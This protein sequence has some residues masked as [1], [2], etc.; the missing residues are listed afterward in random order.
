VNTYRTSDLCRPPGR[1]RPLRDDRRAFALTRSGAGVDLP[2]F[3]RGRSDMS[4][5]EDAS[6]VAR[7]ALGGRARA[8]RHDEDRHRPWRKSDFPADDAS[9]DCCRVKSHEDFPRHI[10]LLFLVLGIQFRW[11]LTLGTLAHALVSQAVLE[12]NNSKETAWKE[13]YEHDSYTLE[14]ILYHR[15]QDLWA[16][17]TDDMKVFDTHGSAQQLCTQKV[18][19][20]LLIAFPLDH[21]RMQT[22]LFAREIARMM[23]WDGDSKGDVN[24]HFASV[25][26]LHRTMGY[27]GN[28]SIEDVLKSVLMATLKA[29]TNHSL[30]DAYHKVLD[31]LDNDKE[32]T[33]ALIQDACARQFRR[34]PDER[35]PAAWNHDPPGTPRRHVGPSGATRKTR[36]Q[37]GDPVSVSAYL[38]NFLDD[39]GVKS[40]KV[41]K[42]ACLR[43]EAPADWHSGDAVRAL[44]TASLPF[45]PQSLYSDSEA[46]SDNNA[47]VSIVDS[48]SD[49]S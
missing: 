20:A 26:E 5:L 31:D 36:P 2:G 38:C 6:P 47:S 29:S 21:K 10:Y 1:A 11:V 22:V 37:T 49:A 3:G 35:H 45:M 23:R 25:T 12:I 8:D 9:F 42:K 24:K 13:L 41:L 7:G 18:W 43:N 39:H 46:T 44:Y 33:F 16:P 28:L 27:I 17:L 14:D 32:L 15:L 34:H 40:A 19:E 30:Q 48:D 4:D